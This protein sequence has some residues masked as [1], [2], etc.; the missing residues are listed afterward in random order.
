MTRDNTR[1][2]D[3]GLDQLRPH[4]ANS[5]RMPEERLAKLARHIGDTGRYPPLIVRP[6]PGEPGRYQILDGH[7]R[8]QALRRLERT[9]ARCLVWEVDDDDALLLLATLN[10]LEGS[11]DPVRRAR[12][13]GELHRRRGGKGLSALLPES[14]EK[15]RRLLELERTPPRPRPPTDLGELPQ[16]V[17]FFLAADDRQRLEKRLAEIG[18]TREAALMSLVGGA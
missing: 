13:V 7:H 10:R 12:L 17:H 6:L 18:P 9:A 1:V 4:P 8:A 3:L 5:N 11:D 14:S 2:L 15:L 16:A